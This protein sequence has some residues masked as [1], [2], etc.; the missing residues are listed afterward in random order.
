M[1]SIRVFP[2]SALFF[3]FFFHFFLFPEDA[4]EE[5]HTTEEADWRQGV[6]TQK[7]SQAPSE[8]KVS[9]GRCPST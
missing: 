8:G 5:A 9:E 4:F 3:H 1:G 7:V 6:R 2:D